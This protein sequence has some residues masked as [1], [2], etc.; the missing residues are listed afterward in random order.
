M[1]LA[2][3]GGLTYDVNMNFAVTKD[4]LFLDLKDLTWQKPDKVFADNDG[5]VP[6]PR[7]GAQMVYSDN[8]LY[9]Y[10]GAKPKFSTSDRD[11]TFSDFF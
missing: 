11:K 1:K 9:I 3:F 10:G 8:K 5:D 2:I 4:I 7:M 6:A